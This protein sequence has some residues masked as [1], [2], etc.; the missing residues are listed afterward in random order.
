MRANA[1]SK[2]DLPPAQ[3][4]VGKELP[5]EDAAKVRR[6]LEELAPP[7]PLGGGEPDLFYVWMLDV[8][9]CGG[10][11]LGELRALCWRDVDRDRRLIR[12]E[13]A[14][15]RG[16]V[17][18]PKTAAGVRSVPLFASVDRALEQLA[19]R[20]LER[21]RYAPDELVFATE[22]GTPLH[23]SNF[24]RR[25]WAKSLQRANLGEWSIE[26]GRRVWK[27]G[28]RWHDLRHTCVSRLVAAGADPKLVQAVAG[29]ANPMITLQRYSHLLDVRVS[30]AAERF[31]PGAVASVA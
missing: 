1:A 11:R 19:G 18:S 21:G 25:V 24:N 13:R 5:P 9:I 17:R 22:H 8:A 23:P 20:A 2:A 3:D 7:N 15:S 6:A 12:V 26:D 10:F 4:F 27:N 29:H 30:E 16:E 14:Y 31:D 28:Y